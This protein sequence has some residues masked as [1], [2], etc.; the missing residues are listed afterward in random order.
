MPYLKL[1]TCFPA[2]FSSHLF[3]TFEAIDRLHSQLREFEGTIQAQKEEV[4]GE[5][6]GGEKGAQAE[7]EARVNGSGEETCNET[8][9]EWEKRGEW[10][11]CR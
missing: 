5:A 11:D 1:Y 9:G 3:S 10:G 2:C 7:G 6:K 8:E 4:R